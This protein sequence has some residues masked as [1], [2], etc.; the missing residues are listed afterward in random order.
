MLNKDVT[1][2]FIRHG[3]TDWNAIGRYQGQRDIPLN[4]KGRGQ[5]ARNGEVLGGVLQGNAARFDFVASP[6]VRTR[7]TMQIGRQAM[8]LDP[9][10]FRTDD[11]LKEIDYGA[12][13]GELW[14]ELPVKDPEGFAARKLD[15]WGWQPPGGE[16]YRMLSDRIAGW[17]GDVARDT[18]VVSH[19]GVSRVLRGLVLQLGPAEVPFLEVPQDKV[20][21]IRN[22]AT[23]WL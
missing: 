16:S 18:V 20:L 12:W 21:M 2:Y 4:A 8:A 14:S 10:V 13:E 23:S 3:E 1:L 5:A 22:G 15:T 6:L 9:L 11:R 7:Q 17:L 19:G